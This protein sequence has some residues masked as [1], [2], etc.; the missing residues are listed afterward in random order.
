MS[1]ERAALGGTTISAQCPFCYWSARQQ[2]DSEADARRIA[3]FLAGALDMHIQMVHANDPMSTYHLDTVENQPTI[4][5][6]LCG[7]VSAAPGDILAAYCGACHLFHDIVLMAR[8]AY[9]D[10]AT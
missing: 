3:P 1:D 4:Q 9:A 7:S 10:G 2:V 6:L 8:N 5:C